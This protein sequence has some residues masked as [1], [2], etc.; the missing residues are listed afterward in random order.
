M[1]RCSGCNYESDKKYNVEK[2]INKKNVCC[3]GTLN[4]IES[5]TCNL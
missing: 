5:K 2:H 4:I 1:F 3:E